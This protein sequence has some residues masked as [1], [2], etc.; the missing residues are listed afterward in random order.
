MATVSMRTRI[1]LLC[2]AGCAVAACSGEP[3]EETREEVDASVAGGSAPASPPAAADLS[4][5]PPESAD[6]LSAEEMIAA[7]D[8]LEEENRR[9]YERRVRSMGSYEDCV[10][11]AASLPPEVRARVVENC[12]WRRGAP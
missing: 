7:E 3:R 12:G 8:A 10:R 4:A 1:L 9:E 6:V 5:T 2:L 11:Q